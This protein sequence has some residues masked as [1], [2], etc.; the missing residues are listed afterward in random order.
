MGLLV[1]QFLLG[2]AQNWITQM[3]GQWAMR[4]VRVQLFSHLQRLSVG[5]F[6][7][8]PIGR[9]MVRNTNDVDAL[10]K[11]V[12]IFRAKKCKK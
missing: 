12:P 3:I 5:F 11:C 9:L 4:D 7:R 8:T 2:Y 6:D 1:T 10:N